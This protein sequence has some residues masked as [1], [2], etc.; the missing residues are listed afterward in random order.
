MSVKIMAVSLLVVCGFACTAFAEG[1]TTLDNLQAAYNAESNANARY[2]AFAEKAKLEDLSAVADLFKA[3]AFAEEVHLKRYAALIAKMGAT[4]NAVIETPVVKS[5]KENVE[6]ALA[7]EKNEDTVMYAEFLTKAEEEGAT[8][9]AA[10]FRQAQAAEASHLERFAK[11]LENFEYLKGLQKDFYVCPRC[12]VI[13][14]VLT[15]SACPVC[16]TARVDFKR[17]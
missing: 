8:D 3:A 4:P 13:L 11:I 6:A 5:T 2:L 17:K 1:K 10:A 16:G 14:D 9:A 12:G 15:V 7:T